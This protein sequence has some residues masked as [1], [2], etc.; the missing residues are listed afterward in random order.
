MEYKA[1]SL[2]ELN[3]LSRGV[4]VELP[5]FTDGMPLRVRMRRPSILSMLANG[6]IPNPLVGTAVSL[7][8]RG[9][10]GVDSKDPS[11]IKDLV[12][13]FHFFCEVSFV[14]PTYQQIKE[15]GLE[16]TDEQLVFVSNFV[17]AGTKALQTFRG[18]PKGANPAF[19][20]AKVQ[21]NSGGAPVHR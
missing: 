3:R 1:T 9:G 12:G 18:K 19:H 13:L 17:Q 21:K 8:N 16:L 6:K 7:F 10:D 15:A 5:P 14:E 20:G 4:V 11:Q 2:E